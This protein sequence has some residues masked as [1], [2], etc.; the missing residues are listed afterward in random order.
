M[1][2][3]GLFNPV[4]LS[5]IQ[6][7]DGSIY[8]F[9]Y[10]EYGEINKV[11]YPTGGYERYRYEEVPQLSPTTFPYAQANR[12]VVDRWVSADGTFAAEKH[13]K[14]VTSGG[15]T[16]ITAPAPDSTYTERLL[17]LGRGPGEILYGFDD[18][19][20]G[21]AY[22]ERAHSATGQILRRT[23]T[24]WA[25]SGSQGG[26]SSSGTATRDARPKKIVDILLDTAGD[27]LASITVYGYDA[28]L[29]V[30]LV[31]KYRY[32][33]VTRAT[34]ESGSVHSFPTPADGDLTDLLRVDETDYLTTDQAYRDR[35]MLSLPVATRVK[36]VINGSLTLIAQ[37]E[38][39]YDE[40]TLTAYNGV[41]K[42]SNPQTPARG[43]LTKQRAWLNTTNT[44]IESRI[45][46]DQC[47]NPIKTIKTID[48]NTSDA[49]DQ[50]TQVEYSVEYKYAFPTKITSA[51]P[52]P[53]GANGSAASFITTSA[54]DAPTGLLTST[55][56]ANY[57][58]TTMDYNDPLHRLTRV[59]RPD[60][61]ETSYEYGNT[62]GS[63]YIRSRTK[64][65][66]SRS[67]D[68]YQYFDGLGRP[69]RTYSYDGKADLPWSAV[70]MKYDGMGRA[71]QASNPV[72]VANQGDPV[73]TTE[74]TTTEYDALGRV[75]TVT[76]PDNAK[77]ITA[78]EGNR[79]MV[80][81][82]AS[83]SRRSETDA[84][85]R[86]TQ[87]IEYTR[88]VPDPKIVAAPNGTDHPTDYEYDALG[89]LRKVA[90]GGQQRFFS[91]DSLSRLL[92]VKNP[93]Q[94]TNANL[95]LSSADP[96]T[97]HNAWSSSYSYDENGNLRT[98]TD[99]RGIVTSYEYDNLNRN[100]T[101]DYS[102][103]TTKPDVTR[104]YDGVGVTP[105]VLYAKGQLTYVGTAGEFVST[106]TYDAF[107]V[108]G[109][110]KQSTQTTGSNPSYVMGYGY[111]LAGNM[112]S[113]T[114]PSGRVVTTTFDA[115]GR[116]GGVTGQKI[117]EA[118]K[119]YASAFSYTAHGAVSQVQLGN[120]LWEHTIYNN[121][122]Q[123]REIGLGTTPTDAGKLKLEY[124]YGTT[125]NN[126]NVRSQ[127][128][129]V[130]TSSTGTGFT[131]T[132]T[133]TYDALNRIET[134]DELNGTSTSWK[135]KFLYDQF[136]NRR[137]DASH[138]TVPQITMANEYVTNPAISPANNRISSAG[139][140]YDVAGNLECVPEHPCG[141]IT[142]YPAFYA[143]DAEN[144]LQTAGSGTT[145]SYDGDGKRVTKVSGGVTT[146][147]VYNALG[148]LVAEYSSAAAEANG[149]QY[150]TSDHLGTPRVVTLA[151]G[152]V[153]SRHDYLPFGEELFAN[154]GERRTGQG[155]AEQFGVKD[156]VRQQFTGYERDNETGLDYAQAR[157]FSSAQGRF[158]SVDPLLASGRPAM[159]QSWN[160]YSYV[161]NNPL[162][163][164]DP[165]GTIDGDPQEK[166]K[167]VT[168]VVFTGGHPSSDGS[169]ASQITKVRAG[170][171]TD[172]LGEASTTDVEG[173]SI[174]QRIKN[175]FPQADV[176][177]A[178]PDAQPTIFN[179]LATNKPDNIIIE[180]F[181]A[182]A[183]SAIALT[184]NLTR[185][186]QNVDQLTTVD[187]PGAKRL[188][189]AN[190]NIRNPE[191]VGDAVN[192]VGPLGKSVGGA[193]N[194][195]V[196]T[197]DRQN[198]STPL[199][200]GNTDDITSPRVVNRIED[201]LKTI[202][203]S[204]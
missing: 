54:Y 125:N 102:T 116:V 178:G 99:A 87:V 50:V 60:G 140:R 49:R 150:L 130:P 42:W 45:E 119:T 61:G 27:A 73:S 129:T 134:A 3:G 152:A 1:V 16:R 195:D 5:E 95:A 30:T 122:L 135:Q 143:Y 39:K 71:W 197:S 107:D 173:E 112:S 69:A 84:L 124:D 115:A 82:Q 136:G 19:R 88:V 23:L 174:A 158:T 20:A 29:N 202:Y 137:F 189:V 64:L 146:V 80:T 155:Y 185:N 145:Y 139:Y 85:G 43:N 63:F 179:D 192:F 91:Y 162:R 175:N 40:T 7:P 200:H 75:M 142:P 203:K 120:Q 83:K 26:G 109:R 186:G 98:R 105:A 204:P 14:Y 177:L 58:T 44:W 86:L 101:I 170:G 148:Q 141:Q 32:K 188:F 36:G 133:Y 11:V 132:Q 9:T 74:W 96:V 182:G 131:A 25:M 68:A 154:M 76:T 172:G 31:R 41:T 37:S 121:R 81:D 156:G 53:T 28:E 144:R 13:W 77:I 97:N 114:Y 193:N 198:P 24:E 79:A 92:R 18:A 57:Q 147:F 72:R 118:N 52:D 149:T 181:S 190:Y 59:G 34:A 47:G 165:T 65:E 159:P 176:I 70:E 100:T 89:N 196:T 167:R 46:Y 10:N 62:T 104:R 201:K 56:D 35:N 51:V 38:M 171:N 55:T 4:V 169:S 90:Q 191:K 138:T 163:L 194:I 66:A 168:V 128:L 151:D 199:T 78:Y 161:L 33:A 184:N 164:V 8:R 21:M 117:G 103:T 93:E 106:Y 183:T 94:D 110:V 67:T 126:G 111:D 127:T 123:P 166:N 15:A 160:R 108:M 113:Q 12:G 22:E 153:K 48:A 187:A 180:G 6:S 157:Y 17:H 2:R